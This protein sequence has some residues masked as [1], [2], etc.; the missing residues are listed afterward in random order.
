M[1][2]TWQRA[3]FSTDVT[4]YMVATNLIAAA[5]IARLTAV[6]AVNLKTA[7]DADVTTLKAIAAATAAAAV[8]ADHKKTYGEYNTNVGA[9]ALVTETA[10]NVETSYVGSG[11]SY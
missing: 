1:L 11:R 2:L 8:V 3:K 4:K 6:D 5:N 10:A 9:V 7:A